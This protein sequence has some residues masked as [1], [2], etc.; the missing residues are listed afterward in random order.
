VHAKEQYGLMYMQLQLLLHPLYIQVICQLNAA[1][2]LTP[3]KQPIVF[4]LG[5]CVMLLSRFGHS[6]EDQ[7]YL[8]PARN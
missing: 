3:G 7:K 5:D 2:T 4:I 8:L 6:A 1:T